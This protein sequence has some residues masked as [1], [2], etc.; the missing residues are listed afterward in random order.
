MS[1]PELP[2][3]TALRAFAV[4]GRTLSH[5]RAADELNVTQGAVSRLIQSLERD[6]GV[7]LFRRQGRGLRL[8][9]AGAEYHRQILAGLEQM[10]AAS[11]Q[12]RQNAT[13]GVVR[14]NVLPTLAFR[15]LV[16][17]LADFQR[18]HP[19]VL[20]NLVTG[21][22][23]PPPDCEP[24]DLFLRYGDGTAGGLAAEF[25]MGETVGVLAAPAYL[26]NAPPLKSPADLRLHRLLQ[27]TTRADGWLR[28]AAASGGDVPPQQ[29][30]PGFEHFFML[31]EAAAAGM[32]LALIPMFLVEDEVRSGR[33]TLALPQVWQPASG[34]YLHHLPEA[35]HD[36]RILLLKDWLRQQAGSRQ[37]PQARR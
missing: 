21:D 29:D 25:L 2:S 30:G 22:G 11:R 3:L 16:P 10:A 28:Y 5:T 31:A 35:A 6:L 14:L 7:P 1:W 24:S 27:H 8:T 34:Y 37:Q 9:A 13:G 20:I 18:R 15:W 4:A 33:L 36:R 12:V 19:E 17:R 32:G 23:P 26:K